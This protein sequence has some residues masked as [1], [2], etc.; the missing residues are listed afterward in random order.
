MINVKSNIKRSKKITNFLDGVRKDILKNISKFI[1][2]D[3]PNEM[4]GGPQNQQVKPWENYRVNVFVDN[5][6]TEGAP[7]IIDSNYS[8]TNLFGRLEYENY[9]GMLKTDYTMLRPGLLQQA[10]GGYIMFQASDLLSTQGCY[11]YL[12]KVLRNKEIG[13][14]NSVDQKNSIVLVSL[15]K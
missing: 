2:D 9:Y 10:N 6:N 5:S 8:F 7:V 4:M 3:K 12:K 1:E 15:K 14:E 13:I 11:D